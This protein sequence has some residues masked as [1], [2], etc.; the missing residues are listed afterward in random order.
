MGGGRVTSSTTGV[1]DVLASV[2]REERNVR[3][4]E[5]SVIGRSIEGRKTSS[6]FSFS[7]ERRENDSR[8]KKTAFGRESER[9]PR[10][11]ACSSGSKSRARDGSTMKGLVKGVGAAG[12]SNASRRAS[13]VGFPF[14]FEARAFFDAFCVFLLAVVGE[15]R[16]L[17]E[18][19]ER[20]PLS[21]VGV[22]RAIAVVM[23]T[24]CAVSVC[25]GVCATVRVVCLAIVGDEGVSA[26]ATDGVS[27]AGGRTKRTSVLDR[28]TEMEGPVG[29][30]DGGDSI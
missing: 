26:D 6:P 20:L 9:K 8:S 24:V 27:V 4:G 19:K 3:L 13:F 16:S 1:S 28:L 22:E 23:L 21:G 11:S 29:A 25:T 5:H 15:G 18:I 30:V 17:V 14:L 12:S 10:R 2:E 7:G